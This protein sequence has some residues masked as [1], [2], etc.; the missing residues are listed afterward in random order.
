M[1]KIRSTW[2]VLLFAFCF[3]VLL[4]YGGNR[5]VAEKEETD[6]NRSNTASIV[7]FFSNA[8]TGTEKAVSR[9]S[10]GESRLDRHFPLYSDVKDNNIYV[11]AR[12]ANGIILTGSDSY[13]RSAYL[14]F[15]PGDSFG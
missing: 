12:D 5:F 7:C 10:K 3:A 11:C 9:D 15:V 1:R 14:I 8:Q 6:E 13:I 4:L 2:Y